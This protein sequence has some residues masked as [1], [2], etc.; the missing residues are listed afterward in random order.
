MSAAFEPDDWV[1]ELWADLGT[2]LKRQHFAL[3]DS[4]CLDDQ[5]TCPIDGRV[6]VPTSLGLLFT[7]FTC[8]KCGQGFT[9]PK[10]EV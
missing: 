2:A 8:V 3:W 1:S 6:G 10:V 9:I 5:A 4:E 7:S